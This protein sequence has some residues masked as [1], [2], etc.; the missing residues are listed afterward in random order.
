[1]KNLSIILFSFTLTLATYA[2]ENGIYPDSRDGK[3]YKTV[4]IGTQIWFAENLAFKVDSGCWAYNNNDS[5][6]YKYGYQYNWETS[7]NVCPIGW[8]LPSNKEWTILIDYLGGIKIAGGKMKATKDWDPD[9][10]GNA[11]NSSGFNALPTGRC[12]SK[13]GI[14][15]HFGASTS[16]WSSTFINSIEAYSYGLHYN[17][18]D[19]HPGKN[20]RANGFCVRCMED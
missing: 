9:A 15:S 12:G 18:E 3:V 7:Q 11:T 17:S 2:Q 10:N 13:G 14:F 19:V 4:K 6:V 1:M 5:N 16:F 8:H 20:I